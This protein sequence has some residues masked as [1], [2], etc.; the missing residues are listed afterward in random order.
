MDKLIEA[1]LELL[2]FSVWLQ[3]V[4]LSKE[5][6]AGLSVVLVAALLWWLSAIANNALKR[7]N[8]QKTAAV[9]DPQFDYAAM[10]KATRYYIPTQFQNASPARE[11]EPGFTHQHVIRGPLIPFFLKTAFDHKQESERF[12]LILADSGM[13]KTTFMVNLYLRYHSFFNF[14]RRNHMRLFRF[15]HPDTMAQ[16]K[17]IKYEEARKT[18]LLLDALDEDPNIVSKD[19]A[20]TDAQAFQNR[21]DEI[22]AATRNFA[23]VVLTCRTQYFPGQE[24]DPYEIKVRRPDERGF[25][26]LRKLYLSPF[27]IDEVKQ[28][29]RKKYGFFPF[30]RRNKKSRPCGS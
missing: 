25:Y 17:A 4:G 1:I 29:L 5:F 11:D 18:I 9:L 10:R 7:W 27:T 22:I 15:S 13:G 21:V 20:V 12:Y 24:D 19:P 23:E 8:L 30:M 6:S 2:P 26:K 16:M 14:R 28:Y 3:Q